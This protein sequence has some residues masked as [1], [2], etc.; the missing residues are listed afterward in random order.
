MTT[1]TPQIRIRTGIPDRRDTAAMFQ[2]ALE[3]CVAGDLPLGLARFSEVLAIDPTSADAWFNMAK[4][5][6]DLGRIDEAVAAY[7]NASDLGPLDPLPLY[8]LGNMFRSLGRP[9]DAVVAYTGAVQRE[10]HMAPLQNNLGLALEE[11]G[12]TAEALTAYRRAVTADPKAAEA[13]N[14]LGAL[15][16]RLGSSD[17]AECALR[18]ALTLRPGYAEALYNLAGV[19]RMRGRSAEAEEMYRMAVHLQPEFPE[20]LVNH[21]SVLQDIGRNQEAIASLREAVSQRPSCIE[22]HYNLGFALLKEGFFDEGWEEY[23]WRLRMPDGIDPHRLPRCPRWNG[24]PLDGRSL[25]LLAEQGY[26]DTLQCARFV[27]VLAD[28]GARV[29]LQARSPLGPLLETVEGV[30]TVIG[31]DV[32]LPKTDFYSPLFS[33]PLVLGLREE[34]IPTHVPYVYPHSAEVQRW[35]AV[36]GS[37]QEEVHVGCAWSGSP[38]HANDRVRSICR[39]DF[40]SHLAMPGVVF[41]SVQIG[42]GSDG[43][44][45]RI[46]CIDHTERLKSFMDAAALMVNLDL[47]ISVDTAAAHLAGAL[48]RFAWILLPWNADWRWLSGREGSPWYPTIRLFRQDADR[49]W[50]TVLQRVR[51]ELERVRGRIRSAGGNRA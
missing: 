21:A 9:A 38:E 22:A 32:D 17:D 45:A 7:R 51:A 27:P 49:S 1:V 24:E 8:N 40:F 13:Y 47:I 14:N 42:S 20:A 11:S 39:E 19:L 2:S 12:Q 31:I 25:L 30:D 28:R 10:P 44:G 41:H 34:T 36:L 16:D 26:G 18:H 33:V 43:A 23:E 5:L 29:I 37:G 46:P 35:Q 48:G 50:S 6:R 3:A 15:L 4:V